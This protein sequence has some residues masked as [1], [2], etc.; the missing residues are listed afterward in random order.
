MAGSHGAVGERSRTV[1]ERCQSSGR[2][3]T[4]TRIC[5]LLCQP[6][7][8]YADGLQCLAQ[9]RP[10]QA[11]YAVKYRMSNQQQRM[12]SMLGMNP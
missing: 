7:L 10:H 5:T 3:C 12:S 2:I 9:M 4:C 1:E 11:W 8:S 6:L